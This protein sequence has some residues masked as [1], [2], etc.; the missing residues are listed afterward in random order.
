MINRIKVIT[1]V[2]F[3]MV[4]ITSFSHAVYTPIVS[5]GQVV[6]DEI[7]KEGET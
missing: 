3:F 7:I 4:A 5:N 6:K 1:S 2:V